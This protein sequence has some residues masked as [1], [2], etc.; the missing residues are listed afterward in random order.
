[1]S[2]AQAQE[3]TLPLWEV[4]V[5]AGGASTPAYPG[6]PDRASR[7]LALPFLIYRGEVLRADRGGVGARMVHTDDYEFDVGFA[8]SLPSNS[9]DIAV[10][11]GMPDLGTLVEFG[12][13]MK[14]TLGRPSAGS[15][16][17]LVLPVRGVL[18]VN[19]GVQGQGLS[20]EPEL[21]LETRDLNNGWR[22]STSASLVWGNRRLN[23]YLYEV[24]PIY[25]TAARPSYE[26]QAGLI[27]TRLALSASKSISPD[28]RLFGFFH[29]ENYA[30]G[31]NRASPLHLQSNGL[32]AGIGLAWTL[33]RAETRAQN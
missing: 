7:A 24:A 10:R 27:A 25:A 26:A 12:P 9:K 8:A 33:S 4:G 17:L 1:M 13:R 31:A 2:T 21:V 5:F 19:S 15:R 30:G 20:F 28:V 23:R 11:Q 16:V 18:E 29:Y 22:A 14:A 3:N 32:S 6:S